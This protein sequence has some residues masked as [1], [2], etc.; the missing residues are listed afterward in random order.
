MNRYKDIDPVLYPNLTNFTEKFC[1]SCPQNC[2][3][4]SIE[5]FGCVL[6]KIREKD[7]SNRSEKKEEI[8][9]I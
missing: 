9:V 6:K 3:V 8:T 5:M 2:E 4:P 7:N 1:C